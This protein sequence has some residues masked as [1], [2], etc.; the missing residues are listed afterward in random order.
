MEQVDP[1]R[2]DEGEYPFSEPVPD[3]SISVAD[4]VV[5]PE[6]LGGAALG[7]RPGVKIPVVTKGAGWIAGES[8]VQT[9]ISVGSPLLTAYPNVIAGTEGNDR[10]TGTDGP[11]L[12]IGYDGN[13]HIRGGAGDDYIRAGIGNDYNVDG[14]PGADIFEIGRETGALRIVNFE[15]GIDRFLLT[16]GLTFADLI[17]YGS[18]IGER[19]TVKIQGETGATATRVTL[20]PDSGRAPLEE[21]D[22]LVGENAFLSKRPPA[23]EDFASQIIGTRQQDYLRGTDGADYID[24]RG[25][26]DIIRAGAGDDLIV[27]G[28]GK[29]WTVLGGAGADTFVFAKG[30]GTLKI[31]DF[32]DGEDKLLLIGLD[33]ADFTITAWTDGDTTT[34]NLRNFEGDRIILVD[35]APEQIG[36]EDVWA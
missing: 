9:A 31:G 16:D 8:M 18:Q 14:G 29:D 33:L 21:R 10:L 15:K 22:F 6:D 3:V 24:G 25:G 28:K 17:R 19:Q 27:A 4:P 20:P 13:D 35:V 7:A 30:D 11:D 26:N 2:L 1:D 36:P 23:K 32:T 5:R 12:I 34:T